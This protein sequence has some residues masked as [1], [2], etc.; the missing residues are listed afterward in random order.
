MIRF[1]K[2]LAYGS[3]KN[4]IFVVIKMFVQLLIVLTLTPILMAISLQSMVHPVLNA[5]YCIKRKNVG[6]LSTLI[7]PATSFSRY[8]FMYDEKN[9][10]LSILE[11]MYSGMPPL[12]IL[13]N[14]SFLVL[15]LLSLE[16][17]FCFNISISGL[18]SELL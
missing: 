18:N 12:K 9:A 2:F 3:N 4:I 5:I 10:C 8:V 7:S 1:D 17:S 14:I 11:E 16:A 6:M 15:Y 13:S